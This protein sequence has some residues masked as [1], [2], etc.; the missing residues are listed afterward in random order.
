MSITP[1]ISPNFKETGLDTQVLE[2]MNAVTPSEDL[3]KALKKEGLVQKDV[4]VQGKNGTYTRKQWVRASEAASEDQKSAKQQEE[5]KDSKPAK[6]TIS[7]EKQNGKNG[8][9]T[10]ANMLS[11]GTSRVDIMSAAKEQGISWKENDHEGINWIKRY[12]YKL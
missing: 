7:F 2:N 9:Q 11:S 8:K 5:P 6:P 10:L 4:T 1:M 12:S 3:S